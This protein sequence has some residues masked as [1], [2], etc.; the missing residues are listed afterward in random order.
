MN[1]SVIHPYRC[2]LCKCRESICLG[3]NCHEIISSKVI[4]FICTDCFHSRKDNNMLTPTSNDSLHDASTVKISFP[5]SI[6]FWFL[7]LVDIPS[8]ICSIFVLYHV[9]ANR[10]LRRAL[11]NHVIIA[12]LVAVMTSQ[13]MNIPIYLVFIRLN[14]IWSQTQAMCFFWRYVDVGVCN[15]CGILVAWAS[16]ERHILVFHD[17]WVSTRR[18]RII[19]HYMSLVVILGYSLSFY[20]LALLIPSC[21]HSS[22]NYNLPRCHNSPCYYTIQW[23]HLWDVVVN[24]LLPSLLI[25]IFSIALETETSQ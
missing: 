19:V 12:L 1:F 6:R 17:K 4:L 22:I 2:T 3:S 18:K 14:Y 10:A 16:I 23:A 21:D 7:R 25:A 15:T 8:S 24:R 5:R 13:F 11:N 9:L 20:L